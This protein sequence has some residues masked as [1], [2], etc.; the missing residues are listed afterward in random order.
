[1]SFILAA[2]FRITL[3]SGFAIFII[4]LYPFFSE[5]AI[6]RPFLLEVKLSYDPSCQS[7][8]W[9]VGLSVIISS[10]TFHAPIGALVF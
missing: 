5:N 1:M 8:G 6:I 10:F 9:S 4:L 7:V 3:P 2:W